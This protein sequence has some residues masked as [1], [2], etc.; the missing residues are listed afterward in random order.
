MKRNREIVLDVE[1]M[2]C[3]SC[4]RHIDAAL[5][6]VDGVIGVDVRFRDGNVAV[7]HDGAE[8]ASLIDAVREAGYEARPSAASSANS[9]SVA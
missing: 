8:I 7:E 3:P 1:G 6:D 5:R 4:V 9:A 2:T